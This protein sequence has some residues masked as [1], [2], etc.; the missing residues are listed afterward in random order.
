MFE[1]RIKM[2]QHEDVMRWVLLKA[3]LNISWEKI[4]AG[5]LPSI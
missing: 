4:L 2:W 1:K 3:G 5:G